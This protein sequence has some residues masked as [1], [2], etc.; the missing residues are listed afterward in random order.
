MNQIATT[1]NAVVTEALGTAGTAPTA[2]V[3][4]LVGLIGATVSLPM[5][6]LGLP[7][8]FLAAS[9]PMSALGLALGADQRNQ[10]AM[11]FGA[12]GI[13]LATAGLAWASLAL[14]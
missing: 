1:P 10:A 3:P 11:L 2:T 7:L 12:A 8:F 4:A 14:G 13:A 6:I 5:G 9:L